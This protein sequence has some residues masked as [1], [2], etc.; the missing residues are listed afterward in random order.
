MGTSEA[1]RMSADPVVIAGAG[2]GGLLLAGELSLAGVPCMVLERRAE[3]SVESRALGLQARTMELL[4]LRGVDDRF[5]SLSNP[6]DHFRVTVG[7]TRIQLD[8]LDSRF[9]ELAILPQ[10]TTERLLEDRAREL[11]AVVERSVEVVEV[12][13]KDDAV[14]VVAKTPEGQREIRASWVVGADGGHSAVRK[15]LNLPFTGKTYD[16]DVVVGDVRL[17]HEPADGMLVEVGKGGI[18]VAIDFGNGWWRMGAVTRGPA[19][20]TTERPTLPELRT[21]LTG[22]FGYDVGPHD[23]LWITR[24]RFQRRHMSSYRRGRVL[25]LGDAAHVHAPLGAQGVN[26]SLQDAMNLGWK[27]ASVAK[28]EAPLAL[29]D[30]YEQ[31]RRPIAGRVLRVTDMGIRV[32]M[33]RNP[34]IRILRRL[35]MPNV[36]GSRRGNRLAANLVSGLAWRYSAASFGPRGGELAGRRVPDATVEDAEGHTS[37]LFDFFSS[38]NFVLVDQDQPS[39]VARVIEPWPELVLVRGRVTPAAGLGRH[40]FILCRPDGY[41]AWAGTHADLGELRVRLEEWLGSPVR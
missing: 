18:V 41:V 15:S 37:N 19:A 9:R 24:F 1:G 5:T 32:L 31:E 14:F 10:S 3:R 26:M 28:G 29:L 2:P 34:A 36:I 33:S 39:G 23:P 16:Y 30:S 13:D 22:V 35:V 4:A 20:T 7:S 21:A 25:F 17:E 11:G 40:R 12:R 6:L 38:G 27:L 8:Q